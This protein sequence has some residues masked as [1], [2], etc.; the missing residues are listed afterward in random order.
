M[1]WIDSNGKP[2]AQVDKNFAHQYGLLHLAGHVFVFDSKKQLILQYRSHKK[3]IYPLH[4][5]TSV[6][7]HVHAGEPILKSTQR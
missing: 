3:K 2:F 6:G 4:W 1:D 7:G 5:D